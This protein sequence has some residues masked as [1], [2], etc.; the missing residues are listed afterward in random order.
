MNEWECAQEKFAVLGLRESVW[1]GA[2]F[3]ASVCRQ[4]SAS[5][6]A[7]PGTWRNILEHRYAAGLA[8]LG[9]GGAGE[10]HGAARLGHVCEEFLPRP[11]RVLLLAAACPPLAAVAFGAV[12]L[13]RPPLLVPPPVLGRNA[14]REVA[15]LLNGGTQVPQPRPWL[16]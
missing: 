9:S 4:I 10:Q 14:A 8:R 7:S 5:G 2:E 12:W 15:H 6:T 3:V 1:G 11:N 13:P 16:R